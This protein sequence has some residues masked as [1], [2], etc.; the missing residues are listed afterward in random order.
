MTD[1]G[2]TRQRIVTVVA[3]LGFALVAADAF[4]A[5][6]SLIAG[7]PW[8][9]EQFWMFFAIVGLGSAASSL[10]EA[11]ARRSADP[12]TPRARREDGDEAVTRAM[13]TGCLPPDA[14]PETWRTRI[15]REVRHARRIV[16]LLIGCC[17]ASAVLT[18]AM[19]HRDDDRVLWS[20]S[21]LT[22]LL[23]PPILWLLARVQ[24]R[25]RRLRS[26]L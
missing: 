3:T 19:A 22:L 11:L 21:V 24:R 12:S 9:W 17:V 7:D 16:A 18:A 10:G 5:T 20:L 2:R 6:W 1:E 26:R 14:D 8:D 23:V 4:V 15:T 25:A 13:R